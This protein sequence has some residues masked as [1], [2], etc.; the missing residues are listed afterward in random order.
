MPKPLSQEVLGGGLRICISYRVQVMLLLLVG[1]DS[2]R[3]SELGFAMA[4]N[5][6]GLS[7]AHTTCPCGLVGGCALHY[8]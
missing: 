3:T 6:K 8:G 2:L 5:N 4:S 1:G 7:F